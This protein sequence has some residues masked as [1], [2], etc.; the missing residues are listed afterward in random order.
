[1]SNIE[2]KDVVCD[3][4]VYEDDK[5]IY[6]FNDR[7]NAKLVKEILEK[8]S[9]YKRCRLNEEKIDLLEFLDELSGDDRNTFYN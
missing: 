7:E 4:G 1:M 6:I 2:V 5:L 8:D 3:Y 9:K